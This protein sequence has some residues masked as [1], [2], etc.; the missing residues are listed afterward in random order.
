VT[1]KFR[2]G[3][4]DVGGGYDNRGL[5][6]ISLEWMTDQG[7]DAG[8]PFKYPAVPLGR[9]T[10]LV[11]HQE[12]GVLSVLGGVGRITTPYGEREGMG[13][14]PEHPSV[15]R[16]IYDHTLGDPIYSLGGVDLS[17]DR[18]YIDSVEPANGFYKPGDNRF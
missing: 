14:I 15:N 13:A 3:H 4:S 18:H 12:H 17:S 11:S 5:A 8:A 10:S 9:F 16:L 6:N 1:A 7:M 2:G